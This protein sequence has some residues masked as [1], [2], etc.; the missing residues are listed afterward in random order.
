MHN[1]KIETA[2]KTMDNLIA[3]TTKIE[4]KLIIGIIAT[5]KIVGARTNIIINPTIR[6]T[7]KEIG[8]IKT[9]IIKI[10]NQMTT[11]I[12]GKQIST[13]QAIVNINITTTKTTEAVAIT[14]K[15]QTITI[16]IMT[17]TTK[18]QILG[19]GKHLLLG[20]DSRYLNYNPKSS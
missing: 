1:N 16:I 6:M 4:V 7:G 9:G 8:L 17:I 5:H 14:T 19:I 13:E 18:D 11:K 20:T 2:Y 3:E 10:T 12:I 15:D